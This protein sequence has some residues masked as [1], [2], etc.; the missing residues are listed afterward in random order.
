MH[1]QLTTVALERR[2][3]I[4]QTKRHHRNFSNETKFIKKSHLSRITSETIQISFLCKRCMSSE[5]VK[6]FGLSRFESM[7][8]PFSFF[9]SMKNFF[10][11]PDRSWSTE[12]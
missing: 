7:R 9:E 2:K 4:V 8:R 12:H 10:I 1:L 6:L 11:L 3:R 5:M